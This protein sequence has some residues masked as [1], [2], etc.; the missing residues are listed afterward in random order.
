MSPHHFHR[1]FKAVTGLTPRDYAAAHRAEPVRA[2]LEDGSA[3]VT[4]AI[5]DAGFNSGGRFYATS[6]E[7]LGM[8]PTRL[9][10]GRRATPRFASRSGECSLG[11]I[12]VA[13]SAKGVCAILLGDDPD[14]LV[15][16]LQDRFPARDARS[17]A[18]RAF[19]QTRGAGSSA[20]SRR[21]RSASICRSTCA[22]RRSS[23]ACGRRFAT[24]PAGSTGE[25][26]RD[27]RAHRRPEGGRARWPRPARANP[28]AV[29]I[30]CHRVVR[31]T[32]RSPATA[33]ASSASG[34]LLE[35]EGAA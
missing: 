31:T 3:T 33:G 28:L 16:D 26:R 35:R 19:E 21:R 10:R 6:D 18:M 8:T 2:E 11:S 25:L 14:A 1:V 30:P 4:E 17:A 7:M 9:P 5:Y 22:A 20:S 12:L 13:Q 29:A 32:A 27:R 23:S 15:R 34:A 24:I